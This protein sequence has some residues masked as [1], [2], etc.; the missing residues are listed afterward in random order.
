VDGWHQQITADQIGHTVEVEAHRNG[1]TTLG[2]STVVLC[3]VAKKMAAR[4]S[5][6]G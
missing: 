4:G 5:S 1:L 3:S 6:S 2:A